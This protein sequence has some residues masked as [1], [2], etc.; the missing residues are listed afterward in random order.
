M[1]IERTWEEIYN[2][3]GRNVGDKVLVG[4]GR[5]K[6]EITLTSEGLRYDNDQDAG[7]WFDELRKGEYELVPREPKVGEYYCYVV[8]EMHAL[9]SSRVWQNCADDLAL[10]A[11]D[12]VFRS[13]AAAEAHIPE[14]H[15]KY[16]KIREG[17]RFE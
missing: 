10:L 16:R 9:V 8:P 13:S 3:L 2:F 1:K 12:N 11:L 17:K 7:E 4:A 15:E 6:F 14:I 5:E